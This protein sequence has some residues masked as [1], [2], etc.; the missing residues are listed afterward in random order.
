MNTMTLNGL[1][2]T[3]GLMLSAGLTGCASQTAAP[4]A[5]ISQSEQT[6]LTPDAVLADLMEG[7]ERYASGTVSNPDILTRV[8]ATS[9]GQYPQATILSCLDSR[10]PVELVF[11]QGIGD[12]FV[13]RVAGNVATV[14]QI[15]SMEFA[16]KLAGSKLVM[17]LGHESCGAV[18]GACD[19]AKMGNLTALLAHINPAIEAV[20]GY[21]DD[22]RNSKN[23]KYVA[24]VVDKNVD[25]T[26][27]LIRSSSDVLREMEEQGQIKIVGATY[28][29]H[30]GRVTLAD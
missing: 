16:T 3:A 18:K 6:A 13:G 12:I 14:E 25:L 26:V 22:Q 9:T 24:E 5:P 27:E 19:G 23:K 10:V 30:D 8:S 4:I 29:L 11:D 1:T 2:L 7:N 21:T 17:V 20:D 15:G 28:N